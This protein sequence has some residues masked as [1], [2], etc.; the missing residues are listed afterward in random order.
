MYPLELRGVYKRF[1]GLMALAGVDLLL[2]EGERRSLIGPNGAGKSTLFRVVGGELLP[3]RGEVFLFG[4]RVTRLPPHLRARKGLA[5]TLQIA[6]LFP[7]KTPLEHVLLASLVSHP[8]RN[9]FLPV[10]LKDA[11]SWGME[12]LERVGLEGRVHV[13]VGQLAYGEQ[14]LVELAMALAQSPRLLLLDEPLAGL[15]GAERE[16]IKAVLFSLPRAMTVLLIEHDLEFAY[17]FGDRVTVLHQ[18]Q[19][20]REGGPEEVRR[21]PQVVEVYVGLASSPEEGSPEVPEEGS[22]EVP[23]GA[24]LLQVRGL[25]AGYGQGEVLQGVDLEVREGEAVAVLG[26]N[27]MGKTTLLSAIMGLL[28]A[29]GQVLLGDRPLPP[30]A[31]ARAQAGLALVPQGRLPIPGL[32]VEEELLLAQCPGRWDLERV[33]ALFPRLR[34]R[35][36][37]LSTVLSG[38]E[39]QML[40][41]ARAL[42]RNPKVLL[43]DEPTEGLSPFMVRHLGEALRELVRQGETLLLAEQN[44]AFALN[45]VHRAYFLDQGRIVDCLEARYLR[46]VPELVRM[47][48]G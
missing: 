22:P 31:L 32:T 40:A 12:V 38:G 37:A 4:E 2:E 33:Y 19:V 39:Q 26:R 5:R 47:R 6:S 14:R 45:L 1:G 18:G 27:G 9:R 17:A 48:M 44:A 25:R 28:P 13:P 7:E 3:D 8:L 35:R 21:D 11:E 34:E 24:P 20:L 29:Q 16:R 23:G 43:L 10:S 42:V 46:E 36:Q 30:G 41:I 15:A